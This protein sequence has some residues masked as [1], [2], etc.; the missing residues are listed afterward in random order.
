MQAEAATSAVTG[1][2][3][4]VFAAI[5]QAA[6]ATG[7]DFQYLLD[8]A[9]RES[10]LKT[11]AKSATSSASGLFQFV[12]QTWMGLVKKYGAQYGLDAYASAITRGADGRFKADNPAERQAILALKNDPRTSAL[13][14]GHYA[15]DSRD[16]LED[17]LGRDVGNGE[18]YAAHFL[19]A[20]SA[21]R[22]I[23]LNG[24]TPNASAA[25]AFPQAANANRSVFY[26]ADGSAKSVREVY[27]WATK[28]TAGPTAAPQTHTA[29]LNLRRSVSDAD[30]MPPDALPMLLLS[31]RG[32]DLS[33]M[34]SFGLPS[35]TSSMLD[36]LS[37]MRSEDEARQRS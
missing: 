1:T 35:L 29:H 20:D 9:S 34:G 21:S 15:T 16:R 12:D 33:R 7:A 2:K 4:Q 18:L 8:T 32:G 26:H 5:R 30:T 31:N 37:S 3:S 6:R 14:A 36:V 19:G 23:K 24:S 25:S 13:M 28:Q 22:L 10:G 11:Q 17:R 27:A